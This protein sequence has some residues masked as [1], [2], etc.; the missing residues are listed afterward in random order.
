MGVFLPSISDFGKPPRNLPYLQNLHRLPREE[1]SFISV[2]INYLIHV[3]VVLEITLPI[4]FYFISQ[5]TN[6]F[7][8]FVSKKL[9]IRFRRDFNA[10]RDG[11]FATRHGITHSP[12]LA[13]PF[14]PELKVFPPLLPSLGASHSQSPISRREKKSLFPR[15]DRTLPDRSSWMEMSPF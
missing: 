13:I 11:K 15:E 2:F 3:R 8:L 1:P 14:Y 9:A 6:A 4:F 5:S 7:A 10:R 12:P